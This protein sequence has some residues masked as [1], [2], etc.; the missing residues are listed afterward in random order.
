MTRRESGF[1]LGSSI[2][3]VGRG[4]QLMPLCRASVSDG[5]FY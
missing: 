4:V 3:R 1:Q 2:V 5:A